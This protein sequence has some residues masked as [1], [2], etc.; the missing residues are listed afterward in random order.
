MGRTMRQKLQSGAKDGASNGGPTSDPGSPEPHPG[1]GSQAGR[2]A[3]FSRLYFVKDHDEESP[4]GPM[5]FTGRVYNEK[6]EYQL[7]QAVNILSVKV[8]SSDVGFPIRVYGAVIAY[9]FRRDRYHSQL[10][11]SED[12]SLILTGP[13]RG[14]ALIS[15]THLETDLKIKQDQQGERNN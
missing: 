5:R 4:L 13:K 9:I 11:N 15:N 14:L 1:L 7:C 3:Y 2:G 6:D 8:A 10:I 12:E